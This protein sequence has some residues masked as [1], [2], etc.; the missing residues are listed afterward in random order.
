MLLFPFYNTVSPAGSAENHISQS[1]LWKG[2]LQ[3][4][5]LLQALEF[6]RVSGQSK[7]RNLQYLMEVPLSVI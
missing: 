7:D 4:K 6:W 1:Q 3:L 5:T 2:F